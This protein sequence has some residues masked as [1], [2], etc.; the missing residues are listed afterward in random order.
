MK[1]CPEWELTPVNLACI[2]ALDDFYTL[3]KEIIS[4]YEQQRDSYFAA[5]PNRHCLFPIEWNKLCL[6][7]VRNACEP[8]MN[9]YL[10]LFSPEY[11]KIFANAYGFSEFIFLNWKNKLDQDGDIRL[12]NVSFKSFQGFLVLFEN[13]IVRIFHRWKAAS[14]PQ[15]GFDDVRH[16]VNSQ[17]KQYVKEN[18]NVK[19]LPAAEVQ[20]THY[21]DLY[22]Y[23]NLSSIS[24]YRK[25][26]LIV[27]RIFYART[28]EAGT[29]IAFPVHYCEQC[30]YHFIGEKTLQ[31]FEQR[32]GKLIIK[33]K[34]LSD[35][36]SFYNKLNLESSLHQYGYNVSD[37]RTDDERQTLLQ[38][39]LEHQYLTYFEITRCLEWNI[40]NHK[41]TP[42][43]VEKW[44]KDLK[45][46]GQ[47][48]L[49]RRN[50]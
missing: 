20:T 31:A 11:N 7:Q 10:F 4:I 42:N 40:S 6:K 46:V 29:Y 23:E 22:V 16:E 47:Y 49:S 36:N 14:M 19:V 21:D 32:Y 8:I 43:A 28:V 37:G 33:R 9:Q 48:I 5:N 44:K 34:N 26:H 41:Q 3:Y 25:N 30:C 2:D 13:V 50:A 12:T 17:I 35:D 15:I 1:N 24:C 27:D 45:F 39:L 18:S 38:N